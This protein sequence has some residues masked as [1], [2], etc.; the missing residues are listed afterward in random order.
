MTDNQLTEKQAWQTIALD[1]KR[2]ANYLHAKRKVQAKY[3]LQ[4]AKRLYSLRRSEEMPDKIRQFIKFAGH[5]ED[6][7][8]G[9][10]LIVCRI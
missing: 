8:L 10:S 7:L 4:E 2:A 9:S 6:I 5:P 3:Y 1:L